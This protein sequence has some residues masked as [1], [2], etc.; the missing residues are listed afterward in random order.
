MFKL[1]SC[2]Y[3][4]DIIEEQLLHFPTKCLFML[5]IEAKLCAEWASVYHLVWLRRVKFFPKNGAI[6]REITLTK[7]LTF[8]FGKWK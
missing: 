2:S 8:L 4:I 5:L 6:F 7:L 1:H 3:E